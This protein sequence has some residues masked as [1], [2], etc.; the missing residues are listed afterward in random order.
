MEPMAPHEKVFVDTAFFED[1]NHGDLDCVECH[2]GN[3]EAPDWE[4]AHKGVVKDPTYPDA[5]KVCGACHDG[6][7][8]FSVKDAAKCGECHKK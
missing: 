4:T 1:E 5:S 7:K 2:G 3:P 6:A 8:A